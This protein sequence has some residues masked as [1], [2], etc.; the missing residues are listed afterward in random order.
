PLADLVTPN[1]AEAE[2]LTG[3]E[4]RNVEGASEAGRRILDLGARAVL[5]K[6][7]HFDEHPATDVLVTPTG[8]RVFEGEFIA[9]RDVHGT[10]CTYAAAIAT[11]LALGR[12]LDDAVA[13]A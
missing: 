12:P 9:D 8:C 13:T 6:G 3:I 4:V 10:G 5:V 2:A 7:G 11:Q 1:V